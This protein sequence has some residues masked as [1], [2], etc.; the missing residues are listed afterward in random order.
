MTLSPNII[1]IEPL[2]EITLWTTYISAQ[3]DASELLLKLQKNLSKDMIINY[4]TEMKELFVTNCMNY[5]KYGIKRIKNNETGLQEIKYSILR[6]LD[7][8]E[9]FMV[10]ENMKSFGFQDQSYTSLEPVGDYVDVDLRNEAGTSYWRQFCFLSSNTEEDLLHRIRSEITGVTAGEL[11][12]VVNGKEFRPTNRQIKYSGL[13]TNI[14]IFISL[15]HENKV[16]PRIVLPKALNDLKEVIPGFDEDIYNAALERRYNNLELAIQDINERLDTLRKEAGHIKKRQYIGNAAME[17]QKNANL[18]QEKVEKIKNIYLRHNEFY[19][20]LFD[21]F[22]LNIPEIEDSVW[23]LLSNLPMS[24]MMHFKMIEILDKP[25]Q[26]PQWP[27]IL[28]SHSSYMLSYSLKILLSLISGKDG[29]TNLRNFV[30]QGGL[31]YLI[32]L[33][34]NIPIV[35]ILIQ[36]PSIEYVNNLINSIGS[37]IEMIFELSMKALDSGSHERLQDFLELIEAQHT[38][39]ITRKGELLKLPEELYRDLYE[40]MKKGLINKELVQTL[41]KLI[42]ILS[43]AQFYR[44]SC[45][46]ILENMLILLGALLN[47]KPEFFEPLYANCELFNSLSSVLLS[48]KSSDLKSLLINVLRVMF[49]ICKPSNSLMPLD[50]QFTKVMLANLPDPKN[51]YPECEKYFEFLFELL[52]SLRNNSLGFT[53]SMICNPK[54]LIKTLF[55]QIIYRIETSNTR[56]V[57]DDLLLTGYLHLLNELINRDPYTYQEIVALQ[58]C[59]QKNLTEIISDEIFGVIKEQNQV[60]RRI[61]SKIV[62][63]QAYPLILEICKKDENVKFSVFEKMERFHELQASAAENESDFLGGYKDDSEYN[64]VGLQNMGCTCF[65]NSLLQQLF[66]MPE[67]RTALIAMDLRDIPDDKTEH[68]T[69]NLKEMFSYLLFPGQKYFIPKQ[70]CQDF[71]W[72]DHQPMKLGIQQDSNEFFNLLTEK[73]ERELK[74]IKKETFVFDCLAI[75]EIAEIQST[76]SEH[77]YYSHNNEKYLALNL[78]IKNQKSIEEALNNLF[79]PEIIDG[80]K[81]DYYPERIQIQK[82]HLIEKLSNTVILVLE[83]FEYNIETGIRQKINDYCSFPMSINFSKWVK[84]PIVGEEYKYDYELV[85]VVI[86]SGSAEGGHYYSIIKER[87]TSS[88]QCGLWFEFNDSVVSLFNESELESKCFGTQISSTKEESEAYGTSA[89]MLF[90]EKIKKE[91][92]VQDARDL[93]DAEVKANI[94]KRNLYSSNAAIV[95]SY[96]NYILV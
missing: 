50:M 23:K 64:Y 46:K 38:K 81:C 25:S 96:F 22:I 86:H 63:G 93:I 21:C 4:G 12:I 61:R 95:L 79:K 69:K 20:Q 88:K 13:G 5:I 76:D 55:C 72:S 57:K 18:Y 33:L 59:M 6:S 40:G 75:N 28:P 17:S 31:E 7:L 60:N 11:R 34:N 26:I 71:I 27:I 62:L 89:Y 54:D 16:D 43:N 14:D 30:I 94:Y 37:I 10:F 82:G 91:K 85:G 52:L 47:E 8:I 3:K 49:S 67:F 39:P 90:Y 74:S 42:E 51:E 1:G 29:L 65:M 19:E 45:L 15:R 41:G 32:I 44:D 35:E 87:N 58:N 66:M 77:Q 24:Q 78:N 53:L 68:T 48:S 9:K 70:F 83:R 80:Y 56:L 73:I 84:S 92:P 36:S 2:W